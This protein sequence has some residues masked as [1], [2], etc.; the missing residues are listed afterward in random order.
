M[1]KSSATKIYNK[2]GLF[3]VYAIGV[4][5]VMLQCRSIF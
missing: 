2:L 3:I 1:K 4:T 5:I